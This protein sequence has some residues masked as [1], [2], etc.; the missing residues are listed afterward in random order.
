[1]PK[2][3]KPPSENPGGNPPT[4][5]LP[6]KPASGK[7]VCCTCDV[8]WKI[9]TPD[10]VYSRATYWPYPA[11][12]KCSIKIKRNNSSGKVTITK[13][14]SLSYKSGSEEEKYVKSVQGWIDTAMINWTSYA[15]KFKV[16][17]QQLGCPLQK[18]EIEFKAEHQATRKNPDVEVRLF[19]KEERSGV[20]SGTL[21][22]FY[23]IDKE[24]SWTMTHEMWH[25]FGSMDEYAEILKNKVPSS[26]PTLTVF[27]SR[28]QAD[29]VIILTAIDGQTADDI[30][31][32]TITYANPNPTIMGAVG[33]QI[34]LAY[35][36]YWIAIE[37]KR[38][39][40]NGTI[41]QII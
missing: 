24:P 28:P 22:E 17:L 19:K 12:N 40:P 15:K 35:H 9:T 13:S 29:K 41:V 14:F 20:T 1:M 5:K 8:E 36:F 26:P 6:T 2:N 21:M 34:S 4:G 16:H 27:G 33:S 23:L 30:K 7:V 37:I 3:L 25:T 31:N 32:N 38:K 11:T 18:L 39:M 10:S